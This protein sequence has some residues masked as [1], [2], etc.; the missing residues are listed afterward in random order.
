MTQY[1]RKFRIFKFRS[2][3]QDADKG[4]LVTVQGDA[5]ITRVGKHVRKFR[6]DE[7]SQ[8]L[9]VLKGE[10]GII[11]ATKKNIGFSRVVA[12]NSVSL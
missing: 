12:V 3:V 10:R 9:N 8:L 2:M 11:E 5:R 1:D 4:S 7:V 6:L